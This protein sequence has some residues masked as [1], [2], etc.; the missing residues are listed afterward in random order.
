M[1][2]SVEPS[3]SDL[4]LDRALARALVAPALPADF[5]SS[6]LQRLDA[7]A[8][9]A[10]NDL[11]AARRAAEDERRRELRALASGYLLVRLDTLLTLAA[12]AFAAG[13]AFVVALPSLSQWTGVE[14]SVL[15]TSLLAVG[16][17]G[18]A[19]VLVGRQLG[20]FAEAER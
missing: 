16:A 8:S 18:A 17:L 15:G 19:F 20:W 10:A 12:A 9:R 2:A 5:H 11:A 1:S 13:A 3:P 6:L 4:A 7:E 14:P